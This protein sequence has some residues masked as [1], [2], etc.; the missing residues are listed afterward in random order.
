M[1]LK[2]GQRNFRLLARLHVP[3]GGDPFGQFIFAQHYG[4]D[5]IYLVRP[6]EAFL[7]VA[8]KTQI[9]GKITYQSVVIAP[10]VS[11][12]ETL[13]DLQGKRFGSSDILSNSGWLF[14]AVWLLEHGKNPGNYFQKHVITGGH[15]RSVMA[16][17]SVRVLRIIDKE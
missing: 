9:N 5:G 2:G 7:D 8:G 17:T 14:P 6:I 1:L 13:L 11:T 3:D 12:A 15:D 4:G 16:V 10:T